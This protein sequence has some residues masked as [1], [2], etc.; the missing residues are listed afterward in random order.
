MRCVDQE[1]ED[2]LPQER[3][4]AVN[5]GQVRLQVLGYSDVFGFD[6]LS[7]ILDMSETRS[8]MLTL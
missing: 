8:F 4:V 5:A 1:I 7:R 6:F 3:R 2:H